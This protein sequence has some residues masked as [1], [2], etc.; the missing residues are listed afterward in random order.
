MSKALIAEYFFDEFENILDELTTILELR[1][2]VL[3]ENAPE[4]DDEI[5]LQS[6]EE[7]IRSVTISCSVKLGLSYEEVYD[8][9]DDKLEEMYHAFE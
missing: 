3:S 5:R 1:D 9:L 4:F 2:L 7:F 8:Q 6:Y